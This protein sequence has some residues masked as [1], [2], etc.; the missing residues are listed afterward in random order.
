MTIEINFITFIAEFFG[1]LALFCISENVAIPTNKSI[2]LKKI[3]LAF[4][5]TCITFLALPIFEYSLVL[6]RV[7][8]L[9]LNL[10]CLKY[11]LK[12]NWANIVL[13]YLCT[14]IIVLPLAY[15]ASFITRFFPKYDSA[16][17]I[18]AYIAT[19]YLSILLP[20][21]KVYSFFANRVK[22][23]YTVTLFFVATLI[24][25]YSTFVTLGGG[26]DVKTSVVIASVGVCLIFVFYKVANHLD[27]DFFRKLQEI[28]LDQK[29]IINKVINE[30]RP[31]ML[32]MI[33]DFL[34]L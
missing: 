6:G 12:V 17:F 24:L 19:I 23:V 16:Y 1:M 4:L 29:V 14:I 7:L 2:L 34:G 27:L 31:K 15:L 20:V 9:T 32:K 22:K 3:C 30:D 25:I 5:C 8:F 18:G 21:H 26:G 10:V 11:L 13:T 33:K 28:S